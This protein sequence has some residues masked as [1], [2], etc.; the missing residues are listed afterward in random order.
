MTRWNSIYHV[1][2]SYLN[3]NAEVN[4]LLLNKCQPKKLKSIDIDL[5]RDVVHILTKFEELFDPF[6]AQKKPVIVTCSGD[7]PLSDVSSAVVCT[8]HRR[9]ESCV[10]LKIRSSSAWM[11]IRRK[12]NRAWPLTGGNIN[13]ILLRAAL[14]ARSTIAPSAG[15][16]QVFVTGLASD[17]F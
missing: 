17:T 6:S 16:K 3:S 13:S 2:N 15:L 12:E 14:P 4:V 7:P 5:I 11:S 10:R 8:L 1:L 9:K